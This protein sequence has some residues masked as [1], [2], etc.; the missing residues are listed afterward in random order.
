MVVFNNFAAE[1][2]FL[3]FYLKSEFKTFAE[4]LDVV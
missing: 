1:G 3:C 4:Q 2:T